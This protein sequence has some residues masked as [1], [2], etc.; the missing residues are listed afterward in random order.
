MEEDEAGSGMI[1]RDFLLPTVVVV[2]VINWGILG[3]LSL[4][5]ASKTK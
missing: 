1:M 5:L 3:V 4:K 2:V